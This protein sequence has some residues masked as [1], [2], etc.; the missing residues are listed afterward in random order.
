MMDDFKQWKQYPKYKDSGVKWLGMIPEH[1]EV[2]RLKFIS[3]IIMGQSPNSDDYSYEEGVPFLQGNAEF[4]EQ[5]PQAKI[6]CSTANKYANK[7]N[8]L[9]SVRAPVGALNI[10]NQKYGIGRGLCAIKNC[11][12]LINKDFAWYLLN[13]IKIGLSFLSTGSTYEAVT[14]DDVSNLVSV[15]PSLTEQK[16][17]AQ[18]LGKE[19]AK[20]DN[21]INKKQHLIELLQEKRTAI[22]SHA[23]TKG[24]NPDV[25]M[26][27]SGVEWLG[28]IPEHWEVKRLKFI[29]NII[30]G[31]SPNSDDYSYEEGVPFLQGNAEFG[32]Q[33][34]QAK[35]YC[36]T[37]NKYA[38]KGNILLSVRAPVGALNIANQKY[39]I[40][41]GLCAIKN[42]ETLINKDFAW[43]LLNVI[44]IGL[45][46][47]STGSTYE[48]VT[49]DDVSNLVSVIPP[50][51]EQQKIAEYLDIQTQKIDTLINKTQTS[52]EYLKEY[53]TALISAA[54]TGKIDV[55]EE[56]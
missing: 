6:Y 56:I 36:S 13:V 40:G 10:A 19:T 35:I 32:E 7:G 8:I 11:E 47:L 45:S 5:Y 29:S 38:N 20:I 25:P 22:I 24:L 46:F 21:L 14:V 3:N 37:A 34:P 48:A 4:G 30:M 50:L 23:V 12:T 28:M 31:Q 42:C 9:L 17:I 1:W 33:Y 52:I 53:R 16:K 44:K 18:F 2:K 15:I 26:K 49:V 51:T 55:R 27:Y 43:Y 41:R 39:G 54:V